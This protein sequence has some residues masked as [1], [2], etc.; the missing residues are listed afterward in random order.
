M[1]NKIC[2]L[3]KGSNLL[4]SHALCM[5][6]VRGVST[7]SKL[8]KTKHHLPIVAC[9]AEESKITCMH[10]CIFIIISLI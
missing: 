2:V 7:S 10:V 6:V 3:N 4:Q 5:A 9:H 1:Y 8:I